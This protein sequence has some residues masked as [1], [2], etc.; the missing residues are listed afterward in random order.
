MT[1]YADLEI[2]LH[3]RDGRTW[4]VELRYSQPQ[5]DADVRLDIDGPLVAAV[6]PDDLV[7]YVSPMP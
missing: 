7:A 5:T 4:R 1:D 6:D 2:G 3:H